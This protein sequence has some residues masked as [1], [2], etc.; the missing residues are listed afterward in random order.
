VL[1][2]GFAG[3][4]VYY[5]WMGLMLGASYRLFAQ[6]QIIGLAYYPILLVGLLELPRELYWSNSRVFPTWMLLLP[7]LAAGLRQ[8]RSSPT[9]AAAP[10]GTVPDS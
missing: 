9:Q 1:D 6:G 5:L 7:I 4:M 10:A 3:G 8:L 2:F